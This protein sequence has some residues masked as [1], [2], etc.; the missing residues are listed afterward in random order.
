MIA[1][2]EFY[3]VIKWAHI[4]AVV[5]GFGS[6]FAYGVIMASVAKNDRRAMPAVMQGIIAND[7]SLVTIGAIIV[8]VTGVYLAADGDQMSE[9]YVSWGYVAII[10]LL[11][12]IGA[13]FRPLNKQAAQAAASGDD[14]E[15]DRLNKRLATMGTVAGLIIVLTIYVMTTKPFM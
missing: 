14:A 15:F 13:V 9:F 2:V 12:M 11:G 7:K 5:V 6:T 4:A 1:A 10:V 3:E 8:L